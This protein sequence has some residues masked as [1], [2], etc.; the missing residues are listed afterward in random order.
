MVHDREI[1]SLKVRYIHLRAAYFIYFILNILKI[2]YLIHNLE[3]FYHTHGINYLNNEYSN[4]LNTNIC[5]A[6]F[7]FFC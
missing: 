3:N 5:Y 2:S 6:S 4:A 7:Y 1:C